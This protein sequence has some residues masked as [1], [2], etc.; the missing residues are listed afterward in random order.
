[1]TAYELNRQITLTASEIE[2]ERAD[3]LGKAFYSAL[4][5]DA[6]GNLD[7]ER[8]GALV[9]E[10]LLKK[11]DMLGMITGE[12]VGPFLASLVGSLQ[13]AFVGD[14]KNAFLIQLA[15]VVGKSTI[16]QHLLSFI[17]GVGVI[18]G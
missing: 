6:E 3:E 8:C 18:N 7:Y 14:N 2:A 5:K 9:N 1:M 17:M 13:Q 12:E 16:P 4:P 10:A 11:S 15:K